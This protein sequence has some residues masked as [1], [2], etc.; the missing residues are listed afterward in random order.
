MVADYAISCR[1][2][3]TPAAPAKADFVSGL[4]ALEKEDEPTLILLT[5]AVNL[6]ATDYHDLCQQSLAQCN[7]LGNRFC[8]FDIKDKPAA[9]DRGVQDF[10]DQTGTNYLKYGAAYFPYLQTSLNVSVQ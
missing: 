5:D 10:R 8:I 3:T 7:K 2:A 4:A 1:S 6:S 9:A